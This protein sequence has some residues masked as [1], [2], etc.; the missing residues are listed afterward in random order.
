MPPPGNAATNQ[1]ITVSSTFD[2]NEKILAGTIQMQGMEPDQFFEVYSLVSGRT[3]LRNYTLQGLSKITLKAAT[4]WTRQE[5]V[6][7]M[8]S[9]WPKTRSP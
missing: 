9:V 6:F 5:A 8:D 4:D 2:P 1:P 3:V 7:A